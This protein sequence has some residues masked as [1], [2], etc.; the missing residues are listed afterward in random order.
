MYL[1]LFLFFFPPSWRFFSPP[2]SSLLHPLPPRFPVETSVYLCS[3]GRFIALT[4]AC[5]MAML[6]SISNTGKLVRVFSRWQ[7]FA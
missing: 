6:R 7:C 5:R 3:S 1:F 4:G 2:P